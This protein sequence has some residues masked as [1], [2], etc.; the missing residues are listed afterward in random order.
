MRKKF[1]S[2]FMCLLCIISFTG[3]ARYRGYTGKFPEFFTVA[4]QL[5]PNAKGYIVS[6]TRH[7]PAIAWIQQD[8]KGRKLFGYVERYSEEAIVY[9]LVCQSSDDEYA[10][11]YSENSIIGEKISDY[12]RRMS[13][14][15]A[16]F[17]SRIEAPL[18][19]F[20]DEQI[21]EVKRN[22]D[23]NKELDLEKCAKA[24]I[25]RKLEKK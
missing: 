20:T 2:I 25:I 13:I 22:N 3:C 17:P 15:G 24:K 23:W 21:E 19:D 4:T 14:G 5:V 12:Q 8:T 7:Q 10:Y 6:E 1:V 16:K 11:Y 18:L 9:L